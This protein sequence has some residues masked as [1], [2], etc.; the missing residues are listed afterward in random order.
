MKENLEGAEGLKLEKL[1]SLVTITIDRPSVMNAMTTQMFVD[2]GRIC[3]EI[4]ND[5][6][7]RAVVITGAEGNFCSGADVGGQ[8]L[9][10]T[11]DEK[12]SHIR[13]MRNISDSVL[14]LNEIQ[15]PVVAKVRGVAVGAGMNLALGCDIVVASETARFSE[16][17]ARRGLSVDFG[18]SWL[19]PR[20]IGMH[21]AKEMVLLA[22]VIDAHEA[23]RIGLV[24]RVVPDDQLD[25]AVEKI[26]ERL[27][28]GPPI[29]MSMSKKLLNAGS[30]SSLSQALEAEAQA[31]TVNFGTEDVIE[32]AISW[33]EKR[34]PNFKG[35]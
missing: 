17:F 12:P 7:I 29:A 11:S 5:Q 1:G 31:Q 13:S 21:R 14:A 9:K 4:S 3:R 20:Q 28:A 30:T 27:L 35:R 23:D 15:H 24:N 10:A 2:F 32:A 22:E 34:P 26:I 25:D 8:A 16:I 33:A 19:L 6:T 18:G